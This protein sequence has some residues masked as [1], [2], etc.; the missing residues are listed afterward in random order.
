MT[1]AGNQVFLGFNRV[2]N[3]RFNVYKNRGETKRSP[4]GFLPHCATFFAVTG[5]AIFESQGYP[6]GKFRNCNIDTK[7]ILCMFKILCC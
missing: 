3:Q 4:F 1:V 7:I 5:K 6:F 2:L